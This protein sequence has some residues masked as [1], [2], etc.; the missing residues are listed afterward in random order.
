MIKTIKL[1]QDNYITDRLTGNILEKYNPDNKNIELTIKLPNS[2]LKVDGSNIKQQYGG[3]IVV[4]YGDDRF[5]IDDG[6][7]TTLIKAGYI[8]YKNYDDGNKI[9]DKFEGVNIREMIL[10]NIRK[11]LLILS[12]KYNANNISFAYESKNSNESI[13]TIGNDKDHFSYI[14]KF[15]TV[16]FIVN[17]NH[18]RKENSLPFYPFDKNMDKYGTIYVSVYAKKNFKVVNDPDKYTLPDSIIRD[19]VYNLGEDFHYCSLPI[20]NRIIYWPGL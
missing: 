14:I 18:I 9:I 11:I 20:K 8:V 7:Q 19:L 3:N 17:K 15:N 2:I 5:I 1:G 13:V 12:E 6:Y 10:D 16:N 4:Q